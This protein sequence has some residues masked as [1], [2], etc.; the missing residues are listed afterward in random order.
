M[1]TRYGVALLAVAITGYAG[2]RATARATEMAAPQLI[3]FTSPRLAV[4]VRFPV[5]DE[6]HRLLRDLH[7]A[8]ADVPENAHDSVAVFAFWTAPQVADS[9]GAA[10]LA[11]AHVQAM[12]YLGATGTRPVMVFRRGWQGP[13]YN[14][15]GDTAV[16]ILRSRGVPVTISRAP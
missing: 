8:P 3:V 10:V 16:A 12:L 5:Y 14:T 7:H 9:L 13:H 6:N 11:R 1:M 15:L 4:P 2:A